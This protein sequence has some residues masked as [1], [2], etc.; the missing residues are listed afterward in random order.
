M[1]LILNLADPI[2]VIEYESIKKEL[3]LAE[4]EQL[5]RLRCDFKDDIVTKAM[6]QLW[7]NVADA[8]ATA[9]A[10]NTSISTANA[11]NAT[12]TSRVEK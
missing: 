2:H 9:T 5:L 7:I 12:S 1:V 6:Q 11:T 3:N 4:I 10:I 8:T